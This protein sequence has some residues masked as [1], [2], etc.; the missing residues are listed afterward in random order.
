VT[1]ATSAELRAAL[2]GG[3]VA[4]VIARDVRRFRLGLVLAGCFV[5]LSLLF[6]AG[7]MLGLAYGLTVCGLVLRYV[8]RAA[9]RLRRRGGS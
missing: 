6:G 5:I 1:R 3:D 8:V 9:L 2:D 7:H 4:P